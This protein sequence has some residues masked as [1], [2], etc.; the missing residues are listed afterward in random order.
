MKKALISIV[1]SLAL[2]YFSIANAGW[3]LYDDFESQQIN[4]DKWYIDDSTGSVSIENGEAKFVHTAGPQNDNNW[5]YIKDNPQNI[6]GIR[7]KIR[8][9]SCTGDVRGRIGGWVGKIDSSEIWSSMEVRPYEGRIVVYAGYDTPSQEFFQLFF[10]AF[11]YNWE[12]PL[13]ITG[14]NFII[15]W[16]FTPE[17]VV[18]KTDSYGEIV[19]RYPNRLPSHEDSFKGIGTRTN[20]GDGPCY[21]YFDDVYVYRTTA[22]AAGNLLL[23]DEN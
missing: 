14:K 10:N 4:T 7:S 17:K 20:A 18:G 15:E 8:I 11:H 19:F 23:L 3:V 1:T 16:M 22:S 21:I 2:G 13:D 5:L 12:N 6:I 9:E